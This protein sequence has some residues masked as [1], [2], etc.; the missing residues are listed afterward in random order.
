MTASTPAKATSP[1]SI[2]MRTTKPLGLKISINRFLLLLRISC[3]VTF[4]GTNAGGTE[5]LLVL[6]CCLGFIA[7]LPVNLPWRYLFR[8]YENLLSEILSC[9]QNFVWLKFPALYF[10]ISSIQYRTFVSS[11]RDPISLPPFH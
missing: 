11:S 2:G 6:V 3:P 5:A 4:T 1:A 7:G 9:W 10:S 8:Q